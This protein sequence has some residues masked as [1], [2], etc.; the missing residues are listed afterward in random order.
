VN[1]CSIFFLFDGLDHFVLNGLFFSSLRQSLLSYPLF[2]IVEFGPNFYVPTPQ[3][4]FFKSL[5]GL[6]LCLGFPMHHKSMHVTIT[7]RCAFPP[8]TLLNDTSFFFLFFSRDLRPFHRSSKDC[9]LRTAKLVHSFRCSVHNSTPSPP[10]LLDFSRP[11]F[12]FAL[13]FHPPHSP[14]P[15][16]D[17]SHQK[18]LSAVL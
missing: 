16:C 17:P 15:L 5:L 11:V 3:R 8:L 2:L 7:A 1:R 9:S 6:F 12:F 13:V 18:P 14:L 4:F 10:L